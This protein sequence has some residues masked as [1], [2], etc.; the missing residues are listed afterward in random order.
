MFLVKKG[1]IGPPTRHLGRSARKVQL[2]NMHEAWD[3]SSSQCARAA[4]DDS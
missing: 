1:F 4:T 2:D 3:F